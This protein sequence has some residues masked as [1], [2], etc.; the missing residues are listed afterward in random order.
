MWSLLKHWIL[1]R[2][3]PLPTE[4]RVYPGVP[5]TLEYA[6][7]RAV[8]ARAPVVGLELRE[9]GA[10]AEPT[11]WPDGEDGEEVTGFLAVARYLGRLWRLYPTDP[12][13]ALPV[14]ASLDLLASFAHE[15]ASASPA[16]LQDAVA[17][18]A[19][20]LEERLGDGP[21]LE[22]MGAC[23]LAD[24]CWVGVFAWARAADAWD[25]DCF[26]QTPR[27]RVWWRAVQAA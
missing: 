11:V 15:A 21:W 6:V 16:L 26:E 25:D 8:L 24:A 20:S 19:H 23:S 18:C 7:T 17:A 13:N 22:G 14:D 4:V 5:G 27:L 10:E 3:H 1:D 2:A 9:K 12:R